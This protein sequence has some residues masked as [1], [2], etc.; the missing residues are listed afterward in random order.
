[1]RNQ[2]YTHAF[3]PPDILID[4][5]DTNDSHQVVFFENP[6][7]FTVR[8]SLDLTQVCRQ[9]HAESALLYWET[10]MFRFGPPSDDDSS[11]RNMLAKVSKEKC[12]AIRHVAVH[13][14]EVGLDNV[15]AMLPQLKRLKTVVFWGC[16]FTWGTE[17]DLARKMGG[18][19]GIRESVRLLVGSEVDVTSTV[20]SQEESE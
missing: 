8:Q 20:E 9:I 4:K 10:R 14:E 5:L 12:E 19:Y 17:R 18:P 7:A 3:G 13:K 15:W 11:I 6:Q 16:Y 2:I 1:M